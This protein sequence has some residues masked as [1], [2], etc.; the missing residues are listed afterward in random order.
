MR[1]RVRLE[2]PIF[3]TPPPTKLDRRMWK[4]DSDAPAPDPRMY[5][6][7]MR[8]TGLSEEAL[9]F[10]KTAYEE[11]KPRQAAL[12][13]MNADIGGSLL[14]DARIARE[15]GN[16]AYARYK[17]KFQPVEDQMITDAQTIDSAS[18]IAGA[19]GKALADVQQQAGVAQA[20]SNRSMG[21]YGLAPNANRM[22]AINSQLQAQTVAAAA[23]GMQNAE[24]NQRD[25]G[26]ALRGAVA[27]MGRGYP[28][29][30]LS[31][32][33]AA[34]GAGQAAY[35][36]TIAANQQN[37]GNQNMMMGGYGQ[38]GN[39]NAQAMQGWNSLYGTQMQGYGY[40]N[41]ANSSNMAGLGSLVGMGMRMY[42]L[43]AADGGK[44]VGP[45]TGVSD[46]IQGVNTSDGSPIRVSNGEYI[47][48]SDVVK[49]KGTE[50]FDKLVERHHTPAAMQRGA[51]IKR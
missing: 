45:G 28:A 10:V 3:F 4:K 7:L 11:N 40:Q 37:M 41:Q 27:N 25:R 42:G 18:N 13:K 20:A 32:G 1:K 36:N 35:G 19:R 49:A 30:A 23:G 12:D 31:F 14:E 51:A 46:S 38:A 6:V 22:A 15:R 43:G 9:N 39:M 34:Q 17:E 29:Q 2:D 8:Q 50:F 16:E 21:R 47:I 24:Q 48:P 5:D 26:V 33:Q 44:I